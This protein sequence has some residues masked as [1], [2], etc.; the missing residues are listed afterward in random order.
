M[1]WETYAM[2]GAGALVVIGIIYIAFRMIRRE[3][4]SV[5]GE[6]EARKILEEILEIDKKK[7]K[8]DGE[9]VPIELRAQLERLRALLD[10]LP[11][12]GR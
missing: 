8:H 7:H 3:A 9:P 1:G 10:R 6:R 12:R 5:G 11:R 2:I 4:R